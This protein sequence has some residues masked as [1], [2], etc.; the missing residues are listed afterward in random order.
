MSAQSNITWVTVS[1]LA[2]TAAQLFSIVFFARILPQNEYGLIAML[3]V[4]TNF[5]IIFKDVGTSAAIIQREHITQETK[6]TANLINICVGLAIS[7]TLALLSNQIAEAF[8]N[9][10]LAPLICII[11]AIF[12]IASTSSLHQALLERESKFKSL[13]FIDTISS[14]IGVLAAILSW[15]YNLGV[16]IIATFSLSIAS[17]STILLML[18]SNWRPRLRFNADEA[19]N[20]VSF[21]GNLTAF[22]LI[23]YLS[24]NA[25]GFIIGRQLGANI[26]G[27]YSLAYR[28][29][30]FPMQSLTAIASRSL[31]PIMSRHQH[32]NKEV[33]SIYA[34]SLFTI[35]ALSAPLMA[36]IWTLRYPFVEAAYGN[37]WTLT[38]DLLAWLAPTGFIQAL[39][40][41]SGAVLMAKGRTDILLKLGL[42]SSTL[43]LSCFLA[44]VLTDIITLAKLYFFAN[45]INFLTCLYITTRL[46]DTTL[47]KC[48]TPLLKPIA[49]SIVMAIAMNTGSRFITDLSSYTVIL[50]AVP[51]GILTYS[52]LIAIFY[53]IKSPREIIINS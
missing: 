1:F 9:S 15:H 5:A 12:P 50:T 33:A 45:I 23:N 6:D 37:R 18:V 49:A 7:L 14:I 31:F 47:L 52:I 43:F 4:I 25:D 34:R 17:A 2:K 22:S 39:V 35:C 36:G 13:A 30:L 28:T 29:M 42:F 21:S 11:S 40:G 19:K 26:L 24:R 44:G 53:G 32:D 10:A 41:I 20:L 38:A 27:A 48:F 8:K 51:I 46:L 3:A 16:Y